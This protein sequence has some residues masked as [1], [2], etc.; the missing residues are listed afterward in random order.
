MNTN[1]L[2]AHWGI[3]VNSH[4][5]KRV[6]GKNYSK[7]DRFFNEIGI[8]FTK[9]L[10]EYRGHA[11]EIAKN[12]AETSGI[13]HFFIVGGDGTLNEVVNGI[14]TSQII[15]KEQVMIASIPYGSGNDWARYWNLS[16]K[17][18]NLNDLF[19][20]G[21]AVQIDIG[22]MTCAQPDGSQYS[23]FFLNGAG[24]GFDGQ[25]V[26]LTNKLKKYFGGSS[27]A[28]TF[29]VLLGVFVT[30][31]QS[32]TLR[33]NYEVADKIFSVAVGNGCF[34]GGGIKQVPK[35][36]PTDGLLH[37][38][39]IKRPSFLEIFSGLKYLFQD[40][41]DEHNLTYSFETEHFT[42]V[43]EK[44]TAIETDGVEIPFCNSILFQVVPNALIM[45]TPN[46]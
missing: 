22:K 36:K 43:C 41:I 6:L 28:Y 23:R 17:V 45:L 21:K 11:V 7:I 8:K 20:N 4:A 42:A 26:R 29:S 12:L 30:A 38:A 5:G 34:S 2:N 15:D 14:Y 9:V 1:I 35:A 24:F 39:A 44:P 40:R 27:F 46:V 33:G 25:V 13:R 19:C 18:S 10:T 16:K 3:V 31:S 37:V 32:M